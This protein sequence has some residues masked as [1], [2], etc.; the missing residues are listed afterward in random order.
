VYQGLGDGEVAVL[1]VDI[2]EFALHEE[3]CAAQYLDAM[4]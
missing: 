1:A 4:G 2:H 3:G